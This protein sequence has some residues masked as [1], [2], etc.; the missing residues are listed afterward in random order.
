MSSA[1]GPD[2]LFDEQEGHRSI[3][4]FVLRRGRLTRAQERA[5]R[6]L[7]PCYGIANGHDRL[8]LEAIFGRTAPVILEIG[9][10]DGVTLARCAADSPKHNFLGVEV[11]RPGVGSLLLRIEEAGLG[12]VRVLCADAVGVL[13]HRIPPAS[14][15]AVRLFFPDP[16]PKKRHHKRRI[17][18]PPF[19]ELVHRALVP[20]GVFHLATDWQ[21]YADAMLAVVEAQ[22]GLRN[23]AGEGRFSERPDYRPRTRFEHRGRRLGHGVWDLI[24]ER[25]AE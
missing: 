25:S 8:D 17:V 14:L 18:Q 19:V 3:R 2:P 11:Y 21:E 7:W 4:S 16:W 22:H 6:E 13:E 5:L 15:E 24:F 12:N 23:R 9:F 1:P 10:G 20:G